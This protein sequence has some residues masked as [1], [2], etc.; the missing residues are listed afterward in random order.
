MPT[1][2][3]I[4]SVII[5]VTTL[6]GVI[7]FAF[8]EQ[9]IRYTY[10]QQLSEKIA[11]TQEAVSVGVWYTGSVIVA[12]VRN[13]VGRGIYIRELK[14]VITVSVTYSRSG[15]AK[16]TTLTTVFKSFNDIPLRPQSAKY[17]AFDITE[18]VAWS[19]L[20]PVSN[21]ENITFT[22]VVAQV[23][24]ERN[25]FIFDP[26]PPAT[27]TVLEITRD[28][29]GQGLNVVLPNGKTALLRV[30]EYL[31]C[32]VGSGSRVDSFI[33]RNSEAT[34][35]MVA[36]SPDYTLVESGFYQYS[37]DYIN[38][39]FAT[40]NINITPA[41]TVTLNSGEG[42]DKVTECNISAP[43]YSLGGNLVTVSRGVLLLGTQLSGYDI[44]SVLFVRSPYPTYIDPSEMLTYV[45]SGVSLT[46]LESVA[47]VTKIPLPSSDI[48]P[49]DFFG[50]E[51]TPVDLGRYISNTTA[52]S[53]GNYYSQAVLIGASFTGFLSGTGSSTNVYVKFYDPYPLIVVIAPPQITS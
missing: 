50:P 53:V 45:P 18:D 8:A 41:R 14:F 43:G 24:T 47:Y 19:L 36:S 28:K 16:N 3:S 25:V 26:A 42:L 1:T 44:V 40:M 37:Y 22:H 49:L 46:P 32:G 12:E 6:I 35:V 15:G 38:R 11:R 21:I 52:I 51:V 27:G 34:A 13:M 23:V 7:A 20:I 4:L 10:L 33:S 48:S 29:I 39:T 30:Y 31:F 5:L 9:M 17:L 2:S